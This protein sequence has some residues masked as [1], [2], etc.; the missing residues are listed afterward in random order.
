MTDI[1]RLPIPKDMRKKFAAFLDLFI[2]RNGPGPEPTTEDTPLS[3]S[4]RVELITFDMFLKYPQIPEG[5]RRRIKRRY[6]EEE[7]LR[8]KEP[9]F[10]T[11]VCGFCVV[12]ALVTA[13]GF[14][15]SSPTGT[16]PGYIVLIA[17]ISGALSF[18]WGEKRKR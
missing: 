11:W 16:F 8:C 2:E 15:W 18:W 3:L 10:E 7:F 4:E 5:L 17:V 9:G 13:I 14:W 12:S 6:I 1:D